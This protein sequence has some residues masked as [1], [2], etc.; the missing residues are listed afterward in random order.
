M[1]S[2]S[3]PAATRAA[4]L[5]LALL[6]A[7]LPAVAMARPIDLQDLSRLVRLS[8]P[9]M[10]PDGRAISLIVSRPNYDENRHDAELVLVDAA[11]GAQRVLT[12]GRQQLAHP[13]W[14]PSGDRLAFLAKA[15]VRKTAA[16]G[17]ATSSGLA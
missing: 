1:R 11:T 7:I 4:I 3:F 2:K 12:R 9:Q 5:F 15:A 17:A 13:R 16:A 8:D 10:S 6:P 14:S